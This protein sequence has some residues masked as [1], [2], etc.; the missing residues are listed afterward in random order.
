MLT[1]GFRSTALGLG[2]WGPW[3]YFCLLIWCLF[4]D[5]CLLKHGWWT[6]G[7]AQGPCSIAIINSIAAQTAMEVAVCGRRAASGIG[8]GL[9]LTNS[10]SDKIETHCWHTWYDDYR[11]VGE[12][13]NPGPVQAKI[14]DHGVEVFGKPCKRINSKMSARDMYD[15]GL[16][17]EDDGSLLLLTSS[18][19]TSFWKN[20][21]AISALPGSVFF[22]QEV[23]LGGNGILAAKAKK[24]MAGLQFLPGQPVKRGRAGRLEPGGLAAMSEHSRLCEVQAL[25]TALQTFIDNGRVMKCAVATS[26]AHC[27]I[28]YNVYAYA[29]K[30]KWAKQQNE[31]IAQAIMMDISV[32]GNVPMLVCGDLQAPPSSSRTWN[33]ALTDGV[34]VDVARHFNCDEVMTCHAGNSTVGTRIDI[35]MASQ[36]L[37]PAL[38]AY[39]VLESPL[40]THSPVMIALRVDAITEHVLVQALP[41]VIPIATAK[42]EAIAMSSLPRKDALKEWHDKAEGIAN[43]VLSASEN[44]WNDAIARKD[45]NELL[46]IWSTDAEEVLILLAKVD[47][48]DKAF[49]GRK[50]GCNVANRQRFAPV[51]RGSDFGK[52]IN[53]EHLRLSKQARRLEALMRAI[54]ERTSLGVA[55][56]QERSTWKAF[57]SAVGMHDAH[58]VM[59]DIDCDA[60]PPGDALHALWNR[61][62]HEI[63]RREHVELA[64]RLRARSERIANDFASA[65]KRVYN[66]IREPLSV[67]QPMT[68]AVDGDGCVVGSKVLVGDIDEEVLRQ[69]IPIFRRHAERTPPSFEEFK[70]KYDGTIP[71]KQMVL[72]AHS[73]ERL[74][75]VAAKSDDSSAAGLDGWRPAELKRLPLQ[76]MDRL[77]AILNLCE[78]KRVWPNELM[79]ASMPA[80]AKSDGGTRLLTLLSAIYRLWSAARW[81]DAAA[82]QDSLAVD[83][84]LGCRPSFSATHSWFLT[85]LQVE[86]VIDAGSSLAGLIA[87]LVKAFDRLPQSLLRDLGVY[88]GIAPCVMDLL[89]HMWSG[90]RRRIKHAGGLGR[91]F[92]A[93][94]GV[95]QGCSLSGLACNLLGIVWL[96]DMHKTPVV[97]KSRLSAETYLDNFC[98]KAGKFLGSGVLD[99]DVIEDN[100]DIESDRCDQ[101]AL[102]DIAM[103]KTLEF[104]GAVD[105]ELSLAK[106][107][108]FATDATV[109]ERLRKTRLA[110]EVVKTVNGFQDLGAALSYTRS[111]FT[112]PTRKR[113][114]KASRTLS[115][116]A[117]LPREVQRDSILIRSAAH[118]QA[119]YGAEVTRVPV[120]LMGSY[121]AQTLA[122]LWGPKRRMRSPD[123]VF[124]VVLP[125]GWLLDPVSL[126]RWHRFVMMRTMLRGRSA[127][128]PIV[129]WILKRDLASKLCKDGPV[130]LL[131]NDL[132]ELGMT[133]KSPSEIDAD[134]SVFDIVR[135]PDALVRRIFR[136]KSASVALKHLASKRRLLEIPCN[137]TVDKKVQDE[138]V[139]LAVAEGTNKL[140]DGMQ[141]ASCWTRDKL[142]KAGLHQ[143]AQCPF[144][145]CGAELET[146]QHRH[147]QCAAFQKW[148]IMYP[149]ATQH[150]SGQ[151]AIWRWHLVP[152]KFFRWSIYPQSDDRL[153]IPVAVVRDL[154]AQVGSIEGRRYTDGSLICP[155]DS[156]LALGGLA[157]VDRHGVVAFQGRLPG[158]LQTINRAEALAWILAAIGGMRGRPNDPIVIVTDSQY[159]VNCAE[160]LRRRVPWFDLSNPD[161]W[162]AAVELIDLSRVETVKVR[163]HVDRQVAINEDWE[164]D[165]IGNDHAD[166]CA[167][168]TTKLTEIEVEVVGGIE[169]QRAIMVDWSKALLGLS[170]EFS[171]WIAS[172]D[173]DFDPEGQHSVGDDAQDDNVMG[174]PWEYDSGNCEKTIEDATCRRAFGNLSS[175][176]NDQKSWPYG[177]R[178]AAWMLS[179]LSQLRWYTSSSAGH[180][181]HT[182][183]MELAVDFEVWS[184]MQMPCPAGTSKERR[185][186]YPGDGTGDIE[187]AKTLWKRGVFF[188]A[189]ARALEKRL[190]IKLIPADSFGHVNVLAALSCTK[191]QATGVKA[192]ACF[193]GGEA[194][195]SRWASFVGSAATPQLAA[196]RIKADGRDKIRFV[197]WKADCR[198]DVS[199]GSAALDGVRAWL[200]EQQNSD[201]QGPVPDA[202]PDAGDQVVSAAPESRR[203]GVARNVICEAKFTVQGIS[204]KLEVGLP[205]LTA[206]GYPRP[207]VPSK[208]GREHVCSTCGRKWGS[209]PRLDSASPCLGP[210]VTANQAMSVMRSL[211]FRETWRQE[212]LTHHR[213]GLHV[214]ALVV[215]DGKITCHCC[216]LTI[217]GSQRAGRI[218]RERCLYSG[219]RDTSRDDADRHLVVPAVNRRRNG[220]SSSASSR[221]CGRSAPF[222]PE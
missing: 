177:E 114:G 37:V 147:F 209:L 63:D 38:R 218:G 164:D 185:W 201:T 83:G 157:V 55:T 58:L 62:R 206:E 102:L 20:Y 36:A 79:F 103:Q 178:A 68:V 115:R 204:E 208:I 108:V 192:R 113:F 176:A 110:G 170:R 140:L 213:S 23:R 182:T 93:C 126:L 18:N 59:V 27:L 153:W 35:W 117:T 97:G 32:S 221:Q 4:G 96:L 141:A 94:T 160:A 139:K 159:V 131:W 111:P 112:Q 179:Y 119:M 80:L 199:V 11:R 193:L 210:G 175:F 200:V 212:A 222:A 158:V 180:T 109:R 91:E 29:G 61:Y 13:S 71:R 168:S 152:L 8:D 5:A 54:D 167:R 73:G 195:L 127:W 22:L 130:K 183:W 46:A 142:C 120:K 78:E 15:R 202:A 48:K 60:F 64:K 51:A 92:I 21:D 95:S 214:W 181:S 88:M 106:T 41:R 81:E 7:Q 196:D 149:E 133:W 217:S 215:R 75:R 205:R 34:L 17:A 134:G 16:G 166:Q 84:L 105:A 82:W 9:L 194:T 144:P 67:Q 70:A 207:H 143:T 174:Y 219:I 99:M 198:C 138:M 52:A 14:R 56:Q 146:F 44:K 25:S 42:D 125:N 197:D 189:I 121:R 30:S 128:L 173:L 2:F 172:A 162:E 165:W 184:G 136:E 53:S 40:P 156:E 76:V 24:E 6:A 107:V 118:P 77:A 129:D 72:E 203:N 190:K 163:S 145:D 187:Q 65:R 122:C 89:Y 100:D 104:C 155:T 186:V 116:I 124:H 12:A 43:E 39:K 19:V 86:A 151:A 33:R 169:K 188:S 31:A 154:A 85:A 161:L 171:A 3:R 123:L 1:G 66:L 148:R 26:A 87:D 101:I 74:R 135:T 50:N 10:N 211:T 132:N 49:R 57:C 98:V 69:W 137:M 28:V 45:M 90:A 191:L 150:A 216:G 220:G 47:R